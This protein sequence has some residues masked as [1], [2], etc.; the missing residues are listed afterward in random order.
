MTNFEPDKKQGT[1][2]E[3][4]QEL[5]Q[6][7]LPP[8]RLD[9]H[10]EAALEHSSRGEV[11]GALLDRFLTAPDVRSQIQ[12]I[13]SGE[14]GPL[15]SESPAVLARF[16][17]ISDRIAF[18]TS[19]GGTKQFRQAGEELVS[20]AHKCCPEERAVLVDLVGHMSKWLE[21]D[22]AKAV[23]ERVSKVVGEIGKN[24]LAAHVIH[25]G[26]AVN[27]VKADI[28][29]GV[30]TAVAAVDHAREVTVKAVQHASG[31]VTEKVTETLDNTGKALDHARTVVV[32]K[33]TEVVHATQQAAHHAQEVVTEKV[34]Q[35]I[36]NTS[37]AIDHAG[38][39]ISQKFE[40]TK[41]GLIQGG[42]KLWSETV[43]VCTKAFEATRDALADLWRGAVG[44]AK[45]FIGFV[46]DKWEG[47][48]HLAT[49][50]MLATGQAFKDGYQATVKAF[51]EAQKA[52]TGA[53]KSVYD[54]VVGNEPRDVAS[55]KVAVDAWNQEK[56]GKAGAFNQGSSRYELL[57]DE[58][59]VEGLVALLGRRYSSPGQEQ[60]GWAEVRA[61]L[62]DEQWSHR[63]RMATEH[64]LCTDTGANK[65][66]ELLKRSHGADGRFAGALD[67]EGMRDVLDGVD[68]Y[69]RN[70][71][72]HS[73]L[74][75]TLPNVAGL[76]QVL[77]ALKGH[78]DRIQDF[79]VRDKV[80]WTRNN[81]R[82]E[83]GAFR[84]R[85]GED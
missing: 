84:S 7:P 4:S 33:T 67:T 27:D 8:A 40:E 9:N 50:A 73:S 2:A 37:K 79:Q 16:Q 36:D 56:L 17:S 72:R 48:T 24:D 28:K 54:W 62:S 75:N 15:G 66:V 35:A 20:I 60:G 44:G 31:V 58:K 25:A 51:D 42:Q 49:Q 1:E 32:E 11:K 57:Q 47:A 83:L 46:R 85:H 38:K 61:N 68:Q 64:L 5:R 22:A 52:V 43:A 81:V 29:E 71:V 23:A 80:K 34:S 78:L 70:H 45:E 76:E 26:Y 10:V 69:M 63:R 55:E 6:L 18:L 59:V 12:N 19:E 21:N 77:D 39:V 82:G 14:D 65:L 30:E 3:L 41:E 13:L 53:I 74:D